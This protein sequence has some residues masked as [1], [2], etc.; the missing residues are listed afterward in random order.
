M[1]FGDGLV[2][3]H[4]ADLPTDVG[5]GAPGHGEGARQLAM[6]FVDVVEEGNVEHVGLDAL[7][8]VHRRPV[9]FPHGLIGYPDG[10]DLLEDGLSDP[11]NGMGL[12]RLFPDEVPG[13]PG[14]QGVGFFQAVSGEN[15]HHH[16]MSLVGVAGDGASESEDLVV[17]VRSND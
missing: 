12:L 9:Q 17:R 8:Q 11:E 6:V 16:V 1:G 5:A 14:P 7:E 3:E 15:G 4:F 10:R 13:F 2:S